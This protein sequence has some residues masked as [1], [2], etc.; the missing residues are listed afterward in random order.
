MKLRWIILV[1]ILSLAL[2]A[3]ASPQP[4][5]EDLPPLDPQAPPAQEISSPTPEAPSESAVTPEDADMPQNAPPVQKFVDLAKKDLLSR[6]SMDAASV[7]VAKTEEVLWPNA[8]LGCPE[9]GKFYAQGRV[10]G[11]RIW[12]EAGGVQ[13]DYHTDWTGQVLLCT[14]PGLDLD[15]TFPTDTGPTPQIG[16]PI[17]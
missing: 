4:A 10:P 7:N 2:A 8:A 17:D 5:E 12:L 15:S 16:V 11:F 14:D 6:V 3:C 1:A 13:Y 9:P